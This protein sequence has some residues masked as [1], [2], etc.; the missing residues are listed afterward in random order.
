NDDPI[1]LS[2]FPGANEP[3]SE[4]P[5]RIKNLNY[6]NLIFD[7][8]L[9]DYI[10]VIRRSKHPPSFKNN[11]TY[12]YDENHKIH[13]KQSPISSENDKK[14]NI[15]SAR[16]DPVY[17]S[18]FSGACKTDL[19]EST[20]LEY[21]GFESTKNEKNLK[22]F[23]DPNNNIKYSPDNLP[24]GFRSKSVSGK[25][26]YENFIFESESNDYVSM[27]RNHINPKH[28]KSDSIKDF[29][30]L[31]ETKNNYPKSDLDPW[32]ASRTPS[33]NFEPAK[34]TRFKSPLNASASRFCRNKCM[35]SLA[36][37]TG[38]GSYNTQSLHQ[39]YGE[40]HKHE[41]FSYLRNQ[42]FSSQSEL[43][44]LNRLN[45]KKFQSSESI[46]QSPISFRNT[47]GVKRLKP[48]YGLSGSNFRPK[49]ASAYISM[50]R[51]NNSFVNHQEN[52]YGVTNQES[53]FKDLKRHLNRQEFEEIFGMSYEEFIALPYWKRTEMKKLL[54][55]F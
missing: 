21:E 51:N 11:S 20:N 10:S 43:I 12:E 19:E 44:S 37:S 34:K 14:P 54:K 16:T 38:L 3:S 5:E 39:S 53:V 48:G 45:N 1:Y 52:L 36:S 49:M 25:F 42:Q 31:K 41:I 33:A 27:I 17:L 46:N 28:K 29:D 32:R 4:R 13:M 2:K 22:F 35:V 40:C 18:K 7:C 15:V 50:L 26:K 23:R 9:N 55:L 24:N 30:E 47:F 6:E 8:D